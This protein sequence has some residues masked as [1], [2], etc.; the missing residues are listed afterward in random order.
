MN[1]YITYCTILAQYNSLFNSCML[2]FM[3]AEASL[4]GNENTYS[5]TKCK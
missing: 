2:F 4:C 3:F 1:I 5:H